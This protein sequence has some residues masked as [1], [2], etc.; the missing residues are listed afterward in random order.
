MREEDAGLFAREARVSRY[1]SLPPLVL[2]Q[3]IQNS[4]PLG[5]PHHVVRGRDKQLVLP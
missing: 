4:A 5:I 1:L 3:S 2:L